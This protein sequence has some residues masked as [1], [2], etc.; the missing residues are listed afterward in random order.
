[1]FK[2]IHETGFPWG[3]C[4]KQASDCFSK[5][6][7]VW[8]TF[9]SMLRGFPG[10]SFGKESA[11]GIGNLGLIFGSGRPLQEEMA[12]H[13]SALAWRIPSMEEPGGLQPVGS[14]RDGHD[15]VTDTSLSLFHVQL[16][17]MA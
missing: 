6:S 3:P 8:L 11:C 4:R 1:M 12:T 7:A 10:G 15:R 5:V 13:S 16:L 17:K 9:V 2:K 14:Q